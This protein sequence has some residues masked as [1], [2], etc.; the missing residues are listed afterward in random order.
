MS[1]FIV[2]S[3]LKQLFI[4]VGFSERIPVF[5][6]KPWSHSHSYTKC[7]KM[8]R[9]AHSVTNFSFGRMLNSHLGNLEKREW[10]TTS[11]SPCN[12]SIGPDKL[13][14]KDKQIKK[15]STLLDHQRSWLEVALFLCPPRHC[16]W[17][18]YHPK[19]VKG[20]RESNLAKGNR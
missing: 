11:E 20:M 13:E 19:K 18:F 4:E 14:E 6:G 9:S 8:V 15:K 3:F 12:N 1:W 5:S 2:W 17:T 7:Q 16:F 10:K